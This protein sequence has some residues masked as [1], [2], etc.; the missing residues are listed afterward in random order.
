MFL[1][2]RLA[3]T[4]NR[5][6]PVRRKVVWTGESYVGQCRRCGT[7]I[8]RRSRKNWRKRTEVNPAVETAEG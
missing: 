7:D 1:I 4:I 2:S 3:C 8:E 5:H 6:D